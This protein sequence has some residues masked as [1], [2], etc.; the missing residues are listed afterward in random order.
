MKMDYL[1]LGTSNMDASIAFYDALF[2]QDEFVQVFATERMTFWQ[3]NDFTFAVA[4]P[5][6]EEP[7]TNGNGTMVGFTFEST[8]KVEKHYHKALE[9]GGT[10]EGQPN[11]RGPR[12]SA[13]VRDLDKNK[14]VFSSNVQAATGSTQ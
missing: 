5:F 11:Q 14:I 6:N 9:L 2:A 3:G 13:Y 8:E 7:A 12:F 1:V 4:I 10:C